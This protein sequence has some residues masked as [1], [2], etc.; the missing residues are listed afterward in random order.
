MMEPTILEETS[1][2][3]LPKQIRFPPKKGMKL[4]GCLFLPEGVK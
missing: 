1:E 4:M 2:N 3:V